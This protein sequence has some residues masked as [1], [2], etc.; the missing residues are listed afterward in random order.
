MK[1]CLGHEILMVIQLNLDHRR[2]KLTNFNWVDEEDIIVTWLLD[3]MKP[4]VSE[5]FMDYAYVKAIGDSFIKLY[6]RLEDKSRMTELNIKAINESVVQVIKEE[7]R[8]MS[9]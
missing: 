6:Y 3:S 2:K 9:M 5:Q 1:E 7:N 8:V 4:E